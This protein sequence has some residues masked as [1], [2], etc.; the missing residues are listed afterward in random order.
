VLS[1]LWLIGFISANEVSRTVVLFKATLEN[2]IFGRQTIYA[3]DRSIINIYQYVL[4]ESHPPVV[5]VLSQPD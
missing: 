2:R 4:I 5:E 1:A 3:T